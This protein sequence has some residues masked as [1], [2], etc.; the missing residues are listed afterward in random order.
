MVV[1]AVCG[2]AI[3]T[4]RLTRVTKQFCDRCGVDITGH[5]SAAV[6]VVGDADHQGNGTVTARADLCLRCGRALEVWLSTS[7]LH[8]NVID[9]RRPKPKKRSQ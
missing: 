7:P 5:K 8:P 1:P 4:R 6:S 9:E 3:A 2:A